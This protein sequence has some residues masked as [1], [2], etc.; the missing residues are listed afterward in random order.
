MADP[1]HVAVLLNGRVGFYG[2]HAL[3]IAAEVQ[4][5]LVDP[6]PGV[7]HNSRRAARPHLEAAGTGLQI[8]IYRTSYVER[9]LERPFGV[10]AEASPAA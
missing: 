6:D 2:V 4:E 7:N 10:G 1:D 3:F 5:P 8:E 9:P